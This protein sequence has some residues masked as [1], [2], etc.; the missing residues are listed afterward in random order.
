MN[1]HHE[2]FKY[3]PPR[4]FSHN[5]NTNPITTTRCKVPET[6]T[7]IL[8]IV[9]KGKY[10][11]NLFGEKNHID[12]T[13][14]DG[15]VQ[16]TENK[17]Y[18]SGHQLWRNS[19][20]ILIVF[21]VCIFVSTLCFFGILSTHSKIFPAY[22]LSRT[23]QTPGILSKEGTRKLFTRAFGAFYAC[24]FLCLLLFSF[25]LSNNIQTTPTMNYTALAVFIV[26]VL[27]IIV[28]IIVLDYNEKTKVV[29]SSSFTNPSGSGSSATIS[30]GKS[31]TLV[32]IRWGLGV[33][34][35]FPILVKIFGILFRKKTSIFSKYFILSILFLV[36]SGVYFILQLG[37][38]N[39]IKKSIPKDSPCS[40]GIYPA[41]YPTS[42]PASD[43]T[44]DSNNVIITKN[45]YETTFSSPTC[46]FFLQN[47]SS[48]LWKLSVSI[49]WL[50]LCGSWWLILLFF[51]LSKLFMNVSQNQ[52]Q[53]IPNLNIQITRNPLY[54]GCRTPH[55]KL[56]ED[57]EIG[58]SHCMQQSAADGGVIHGMNFEKTP[59]ND[60]TPWLSNITKEMNARLPIQPFV[61]FF[62]IPYQ[63]KFNNVEENNLQLYE[64]WDDYSDIL[65]GNPFLNNN[66]IPQVHVGANPYRNRDIAIYMNNHY[67]DIPPTQPNDFLVFNGANV[68][69]AEPRPRTEPCGT[70]ET[71]QNL[72]FLKNGSIES[73]TMD[74]ENAFLPA[75]RKFTGRDPPQDPKLSTFHGYNLPGGNDQEIT[76]D[77]KTVDRG[78]VVRRWIPMF[79]FELGIILVIFV[80]LGYAI[81]MRRFFGIMQDKIKESQQKPSSSSDNL[82]VF[83]EAVDSIFYL[84]G[85]LTTMIVIDSLVVLYW[86]FKVS[87]SMTAFFSIFQSRWYLVFIPLVTLTLVLLLIISFT[88]DITK[89]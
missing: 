7:P 61:G 87:Y 20:L 76:N 54:H 71:L 62:T 78:Q 56:K 33:L 12:V 21:I 53:H 69:N 24:F 29:S 5:S 3:F 86:L 74:V 80:H 57:V 26:F 44:S 48:Y 88:A 60:N 15:N 72:Y 51:Y 79:V 77:Q 34:L 19:S 68:L 35:F 45:N 1:T 28:R 32:G 23:D 36:L 65:N 82:T 66:N 2:F 37:D 38:I 41:F 43:P 64:D 11:R 10:T 59:V 13:H 18:F 58:I 25:L 4:K 30:D 84:N 46:S 73:K 83:S 31:S 42:D 40:Y 75:Y 50:V 6:E 81:R 70:E 17:I 63:P 52:L 39:S 55:D 22:I 14:T 16:V 47:R 8:S 49:F 27:I 67:F 89:Y 9:N 85:A